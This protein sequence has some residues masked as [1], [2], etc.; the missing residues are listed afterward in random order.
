MGAGV[1]RMEPAKRLP[2]EHLV[3][4]VLGEVRPS[5]HHAHEHLGVG[6]EVIHDVREEAEPDD[7]Q[8]LA[9]GRPYTAEYQAYCGRTAQL[10][11]EQKG[12]KAPSLSV[13]WLFAIGGVDT[14]DVH[15]DESTIPADAPATLAEGR[16]WTL[17]DC[18][19]FMRHC[20]E[21]ILSRVLLPGA[22]TAALHLDEKAVHVQAEGPAIV[23]DGQGGYRIGNNAVREAVARLALGFDEANARARAKLAEREEQAVAEEER[24]LAADPDAQLPKRRRW[25]DKG[26]DHVYLT[27]SAQMRLVHDLYAE[28][29]ARFGVE[30]GKGG[31]MRHHERVDRSKAME[32]KLRAVQRE[33]EAAKVRAESAEQRAEEARKVVAEH[34]EVWTAREREIDERDRGRRGKVAGIVRTARRRLDARSAALVERDLAAKEQ[35]D[36]LREREAAASALETQLVE[37]KV[38]QDRQCKQTARLLKRALSRRGELETEVRALEQAGD[39]LR[40]AVCGASAELH[41]IEQRKLGLFGRLVARA[42][43]FRARLNAGRRRRRELETDNDERTAQLAKLDDL[44]ERTRTAAH[45]WE[46]ERAKASDAAVLA[47][48]A[49]EASV[50]RRRDAE[51][52]ADPVEVVRLLYSSFQ[53]LDALALL[54]ERILSVFNE[55]AGKRSVEPVFELERDLRAQE[56][57]RAELRTGLRDSPH[58]RTEGGIG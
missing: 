23:S 5:T 14:I 41:G 49:E 7:P 48:A 53:F 17:A 2:D 28:E 16:P 3:A 30:R 37:R 10:A 12:G 42:R 13:S 55:I 1:I 50:R 40:D 31:A 24:L 51:A 18:R 19:D 46:L 22:Y 27:A 45:A 54:P 32:A 56:E 34:R 8:T 26:E 35:A 39:K 11:A 29:F 4:H 57:K 58:S 33:A 43:R 25:I 47:R 52:A 44:V 21:R 36:D 6:V 20:D 15:A 38:D 9:E